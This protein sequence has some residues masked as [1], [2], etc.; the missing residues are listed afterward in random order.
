MNFEK[1]TTSTNVILLG[2]HIH[3]HFKLPFFVLI[4]NL[5]SMTVV[6]NIMIIV[7]VSSSQFLHHP[8]FFFLSHLSLSDMI[9]TTTIVPLMLT[10]IMKGQVALSVAACIIQFN[11]FCIALGS[12]SLL[13]AVMSFDRYLAIC[14]PLQYM[15]IMDKKLRIHLVSL[16]WCS[17]VAIAVT[18]ALTI[19]TLTFYTTALELEQKLLATPSS[20]FPFLFSIVTYIYI[21]ITVLRIPTTSGKQKA[22]S[23]FSSHLTIVCIFF[24]SLIGLYLVPSPNRNP[25][26]AHKVVS[27]HDTVVTPLFNPL[28]YTTRNADIKASLKKYLWVFKAAKNC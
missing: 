13:L 23:T 9:L 20:V 17:S 28:I 24:G 16:C 2:F 10:G 19:S 11:F 4:L 21:F 8:M 25:F 3:N 14:N 7:L 18:L 1:L 12:E 6:A 26:S 22:Y 5:Y 27:L 15:I